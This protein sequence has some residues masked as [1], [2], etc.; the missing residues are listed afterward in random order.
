M[1]IREQEFIDAAVSQGLITDEQLP[2]IRR[3]ARDRQVTTL[4]AISISYRVPLK[5]LYHAVAAERKIRFV[6]LAIEPIDE[7]AAQDMP[8]VAIQ[9]GVVPLLDADGKTILA[10]AE[11]DDLALISSV[12]RSLDV[13]A[14]VALA[15]PD[16]IADSLQYIR[17]L[18]QTSGGAIV[19]IEQEDA[20]D[21]FDR[22]INEAYL[23]HA[24]DIHIEPSE[25]TIRVRFRVDGRLISY[26]S[27]LPAE[28]GR[29]LV[30]RIKV[31]SGL[32]IA[33][34][35]APQ[36]G[37]MQY[38]LANGV[39]Q[40][41]RV[42][43]IPTRFGERITIRL[44]GTTDE[45]LTLETLGML[46]ADLEDFRQA[47]QRPHGIVL[48][49]GPT[50]SG[51]STT[52]YS[53]LKEI[54]S[55]WRNI[56]TVEDPIEQIVPNISQVQVGASDKVTFDSALR[57]ILRHDPDVVMIGEIR[58][59]PT[60]DIALKAAL[61]GHLV[62]SSLHT[63]TAIGA[64][65]RLMDFGCESYLVG[66][67]LAGAISQ[68]LVRRLC[69]SCSEQ[70]DLDDQQKTLIGG[71]DLDHHYIPVGCPQCLGTGYSGRIG[72]FE[73]FWTGEETRKLIADGAS[74]QD[75]SRVGGDKHKTMLA[76]GLEKVALGL[77]SLEEVIG[78]TIGDTI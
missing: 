52:L 25:N 1:P 29:Q 46:D 54:N 6:D 65:T 59:L 38:E 61:T 76:D 73:C 27:T 64:V 49:T 28:S 16:A 18:R 30:S 68:R 9:R 60:A 5:A 48:L 69:K 3:V 4:E 33:E 58:D 41:M 66:A 51:K 37:R 77:T 67:T 34:Q 31:F 55:G 36:D 10:T 45:N 74:E 2:E 11:V 22:V 62:F 43:V 26:I 63:N 23:H 44:L 50:G 75:I 72:L 13:L 24:S 70:T 14:E 57:S 21:L 32:D 78:V 17:T 12:E 42:A 39:S 8:D 15:A 47:I 7:Q 40:D 19:E 53:A 71:F 56:I 35:R 20:V